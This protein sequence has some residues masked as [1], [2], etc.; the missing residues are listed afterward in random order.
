MYWRFI[1][2]LCWGMIH[3][4]R[5]QNRYYSINRSHLNKIM[6]VFDCC[7]DYYSEDST[8]V[9]LVYT[10]QNK[11]VNNGSCQDVYAIDIKLNNIC[12]ICFIRF[13]SREQ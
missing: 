9:K 12:A 10:N 2:N 7:M 8:K 4:F 1:K 6:M 13:T 3:K 11:L 5:I